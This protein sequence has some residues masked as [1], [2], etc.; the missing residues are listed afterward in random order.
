MPWRLTTANRRIASR[1]DRNGSHASSP[2]AASLTPI[3]RGYHFSKRGSCSGGCSLRLR[4]FAAR[5]AAIRAN[6]R[7][8]LSARLLRRRK[9]CPHVIII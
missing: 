2:V 3:S 5:M 1:S 4:A 8:R 6:R 7:T 9:R